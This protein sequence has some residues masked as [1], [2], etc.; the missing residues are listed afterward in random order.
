MLKLVWLSDR[1][2]HHQC[3]LVKNCLQNP[4][5]GSLYIIS[6]HWL[7]HNQSMQ[8]WEKQPTTNHSSPFTWSWSIL[9]SCSTGKPTANTFA[10]PCHLSAR[11]SE[12]IT[13]SIL[14]QNR[15]GKTQTLN[16][17][18][19]LSLDFYILKFTQGTLGVILFCRKLLHAGFKKIRPPY[20]LSL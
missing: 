2:W 17:R 19:K 15:S 11:R 9:L 13:A 3:F 6:W 1:R 18:R 8:N 12:V 16:A 20:S 10:L 7:T 14:I 5:G 4:L